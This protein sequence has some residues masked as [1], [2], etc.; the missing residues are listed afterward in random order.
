V[1]ATIKVQGRNETKGLIRRIYNV[2]SWFVIN[3]ALHPTG[4]GVQKS[5]K[6]ASYITVTS[7][8]NQHLY[9]NG[10]EALVLQ[11]INTYNDEIILATA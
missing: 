2:L 3:A 4:A 8:E 6:Y 5:M 1:D 9:L 11:K 10:V 7:P